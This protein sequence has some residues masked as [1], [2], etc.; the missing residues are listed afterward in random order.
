MTQ[1]VRSRAF[2]QLT[3]FSLIDDVSLADVLRSAIHWYI[4]YR[5]DDPDLRRALRQAKAN[6]ET[7]MAVLAA[8]SE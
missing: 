5:E 2:D 7:T 6:Y 8:G 4:A 3:A 1:R